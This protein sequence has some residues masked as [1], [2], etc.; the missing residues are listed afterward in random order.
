MRGQSSKRPRR[1]LRSA[2]VN[3]WLFQTLFKNIFTLHECHMRLN[4]RKIVGD[5]FPIRTYVLL[6]SNRNEILLAKFCREVLFVMIMFDDFIEFR[7]GVR[8][9]IPVSL[10]TDG[11]AQL[12]LH[13][14]WL[15]LL[16]KC[17]SYYPVSSST[18]CMKR[19]IS[20]EYSLKHQHLLFAFVKTKHSFPICLN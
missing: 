13:S 16:E 19:S 15:R 9:A 6:L 12:Q 20:A 1:R 3:R 17:H 8:V 18:D 4:G 2:D 14:I 7:K 11:S 5:I 10:S